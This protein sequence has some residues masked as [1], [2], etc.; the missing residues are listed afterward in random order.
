[1][2]GLLLLTQ[3]RA[4]L[5][6]WLQGFMV[7]TFLLVLV[8]CLYALCELFLTTLLNSTTLVFKLLFS[9]GT[10]LTLFGFSFLLLFITGEVFY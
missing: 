10:L 7:S 8:S 3:Y 1:M 9:T 4:Q 2:L 5:F 6:I